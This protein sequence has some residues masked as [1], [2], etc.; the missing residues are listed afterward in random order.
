MRE[1]Q[2]ENSDYNLKLALSGLSLEYCSQARL[3]DRYC[4]RLNWAGKTS[5]HPTS[6][7]A[8]TVLLAL[9][10]IALVIIA[11]CSKYSPPST[12]P[13]ASTVAAQAAPANDYVG[14]GACAKCHLAEFNSHR[15]T[16]HAHTFR[17]FTASALGK[18]AP[19]QTLFEDINA[20]IALRSDH[21]ML[22]NPR[23]M[24]TKP[25]QFA[26]GSGKQGLTFVAA[27]NSG[28]FE[29][30]VSYIPRTQEW[31][32][33]P[34]QEGERNNRNATG[35]L[36]LGRI[37]HACIVCHAV[38]APDNRFY[39]D[40][41]FM[42]V[43]CESCHGPGSAHIATMSSGAG[44]DIKM[45]RLSAASS[46][47]IDAVC[48]KCHRSTSEVAAMPAPQRLTQRFMV[49]GLEKSRCFQGS[50][51]HLNCITC[52]D[53]HKD[54]S[55][56]HKSYERICLQ[57]HSKATAALASTGQRTPAPATQSPHMCPVN[58]RNG[59]IDCHMP[60]RSVF[61]GN[62]NKIPITMADHWIK[63]NRR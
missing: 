1:R 43:G 5:M 51:S 36:W 29:M 52:H 19:P 15:L 53:P 61:S 26:L 8:T 24:Q 38:T 27:E 63:I 10:V 18:Q 2:E 25:L 12:L 33:T 45:E 35:K 40:E 34:G 60:R 9:P 41:Q 14:S 4:V 21:Y 54:A 7:R 48:A 28:V 55:L 11:G 58:P 30:R 62:H 49:Y 13:S 3:A 17:P 47:Q 50:N 20:A 22:V 39:P 44:T 32:M 57:C 56:D 31:Y 23:T 37:G 16:H 59:C 46:L 42:G 6:F